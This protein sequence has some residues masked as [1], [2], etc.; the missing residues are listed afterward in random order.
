MEQELRDSRISIMLHLLAGAAMGIASPFFGRALYAVGAV[1]VAA[2]VI[3]HAMERVVGKKAF[4]WWMGNG[5]FVYLFVWLD[6][7][8]I[9]FNVPL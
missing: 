7:W 1:I 3:G 4:S 2:F 6:A 8:V 9:S 5:L